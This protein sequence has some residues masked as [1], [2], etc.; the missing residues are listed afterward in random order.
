MTSSSSNIV[1]IL[2]SDVMADVF[3][4]L[5][6]TGTAKCSQVCRQWYR[7]ATISRCLWRQFVVDDFRLEEGVESVDWR[8]AYSYLV[9]KLF[10][11]DKQ[12][13]DRTWAPLPARVVFSDDGSAVPGYPP[14]AAIRRGLGAW[15]T[16][17]G[18]EEDVDLVLKL[19][20]LCMVTSFEVANGGHFYSAPLKE[21]LIF[22][23]TQP[24]DLE[25]ARKF[26]GK[27]GSE[28]VDR[29]AGAPNFNANPNNGSSEPLI[30]LHFPPLPQAFNARH[31]RRLGRR[32][33]L[34]R[35]IH[36]KLLSSYNYPGMLS[37]NIDV[38]DLLTYGCT[39]PELPSLLQTPN[40]NA[41]LPEDPSYRRM[42]E[43][44]PYPY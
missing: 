23:S 6:A 8:K 4:F 26:N 21:A 35:Y 1:E 22:T 28:W 34:A 15:C 16:N 11:C 27:E 5:G 14:E 44:R 20:Q 24:V 9:Q 40:L 33:V 38:Q 19:P 32:P 31:H 13:K 39:L 37:D 30:G 10:D 25:A 29:L 42:H 3:S 43:I 36:F 18:V 2:G 17:A 12:E 41:Q 7:V